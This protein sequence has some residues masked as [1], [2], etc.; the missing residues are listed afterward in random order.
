MLFHEGRELCGRATG[1]LPLC[2]CSPPNNTKG[3]SFWVGG[4]GGVGG[5]LG[6]VSQAPATAAYPPSTGSDK[7]KGRGA[8]RNGPCLLAWLNRA[9]MRLPPHPFFPLL[10]Q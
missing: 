8:G 3:G 2:V 5:G 9:K 10:E 6:R 7:S 1:S 4:D